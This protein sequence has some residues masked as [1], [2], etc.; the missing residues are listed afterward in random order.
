M[1]IVVFLCGSNGPIVKMKAGLM[2]YHF[3]RPY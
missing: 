1:R 2:P 3:I